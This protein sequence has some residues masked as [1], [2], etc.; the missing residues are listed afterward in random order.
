MN[1]KRHTLDDTQSEPPPQGQE[2]DQLPEL[3]G[4]PH[5]GC[6]SFK[7]VPL[8]PLVLK[9]GCIVESSGKFYKL[10]MLVSHSQRL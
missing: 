2:K 6:S 4:P 8:G 5:S 9:L 3:C 10:L 1:E 7:F